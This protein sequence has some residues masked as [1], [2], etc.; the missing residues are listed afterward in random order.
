MDTRTDTFLSVVDRISR[1]LGPVNNLVAH[2]VD[3]MAPQTIARAEMCPPPGAKVCYTYCAVDDICCGP[4]DAQNKIV[5]YSIHIG[6][7]EVQT[8]ICSVGCGYGCP[9][10]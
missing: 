9:A 4:S 5:V 1:N 7:C 6:G 10:C 8:S 3:R 2:I